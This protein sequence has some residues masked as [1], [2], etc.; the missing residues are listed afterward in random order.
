MS[1]GQPSTPSI[2]FPRISALNKVKGKY[3]V[4][5]SCPADRGLVVPPKRFIPQGAIGLKGLGHMVGKNIVW[6]QG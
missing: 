5:W 6:K 2:P 4:F 3:E 1:K